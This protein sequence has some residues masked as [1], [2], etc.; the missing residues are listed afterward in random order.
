MKKSLILL[1]AL[2]TAVNSQAQLLWKVSGGDTA[3]PSYLFG[4]IH[5]ETAQYIDSVPGLNEAL[6]EVDVV[7]GEVFKDD[8]VKP[9]MIM[10][11]MTDVM[12]PADST[13]DKLIT[14]AEYQLVDSVVKDYLLGM[15]GLQY[16]KHLKPAVVSI[17]LNVL[18]MQKYFPEF[19][20]TGDAIDLAVQNKGLELGKYVAG[21]ETVDD[22]MQA[23]FGSPLTEQAQ[24]LVD[25]CRNDTNF[26]E[27][28]AH[29]CEAYHAQDL[30]ALE[31]II[32]DPEIGMSEEQTE[33]LSNT[34]NRKWMDKITKTLPV[35]SAL[36]VVGAA[37]L[38]G[39]QGLITLLRESGYT[40]EPVT[41]SNQ[42]NQCL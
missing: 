11:M 7:Y 41:T 12:A 25:F 17:Q 10:K 35:Q 5:L 32:Y 26:T 22:Q 29:L 1:V 36:V 28:N 31:R 33:R 15:V 21:L 19:S 16:L 9:E 23:L 2:A 20:S 40:V 14:P 30:D 38:I 8:L 13:I 4:T 37:H 3:K 27:Y 24:D 39:K 6:K 18:Q 42:V 34:R